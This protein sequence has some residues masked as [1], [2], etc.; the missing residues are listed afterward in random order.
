[1][2]LQRTIIRWTHIVISMP[3]AGY[4][5]G[6]PLVVYKYRFGPRYVFIPIMVLSGLWMWKGHLV[7]RLLS[8][9]SAEARQTP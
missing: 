9:I 1:M 3:I 6:A 2:S 7:H 5:Y 8:R 4:I